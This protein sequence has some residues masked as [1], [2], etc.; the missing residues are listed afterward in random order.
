MN[1]NGLRSGFRIVKRKTKL[2]KNSIIG[3]GSVITKSVSKKS[4]A[5]TRSAQVEVKNYKRKK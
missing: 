3:A 5:L 1:Y 4:L 2:N